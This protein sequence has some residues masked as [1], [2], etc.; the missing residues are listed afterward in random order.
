MK[1][2]EARGTVIATR[3]DGEKLQAVSVMNF[4]GVAPPRR[5]VKPTS[6]YIKL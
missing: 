3:Q 6:P 5:V 1:A 4:K 2:T